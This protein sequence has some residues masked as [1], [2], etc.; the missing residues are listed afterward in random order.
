[1]RRFHSVIR[2]DVHCACD[3]PAGRFHQMHF[4]A[5]F[6]GVHHLHAERGGKSYDAEGGIVFRIVGDKATDLDECI[7]DIDRSDAFWG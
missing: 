6:K 2:T 3:S 7:D 5:R 1:M 4:A